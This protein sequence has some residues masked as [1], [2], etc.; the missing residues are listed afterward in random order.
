[1]QRAAASIA[2]EGL[3]RVE[4]CE[5]VAMLSHDSGGEGVGEDALWSHRRDAISAHQGAIKAQSRRN[6]GAIKAHQGAIKAQSRRN[7]GASS[8]YLV[9]QARYRRRTLRVA[10]RHLLQ[11]DA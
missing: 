11:E 2:S 1:M 8:L 3:R 10:Q 5:G 7:Q 9:P 6:Q 4:P